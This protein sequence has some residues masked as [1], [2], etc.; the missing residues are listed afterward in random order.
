MDAQNQFFVKNKTK[1]MVEKLCMQIA[2]CSCC[3]SFA[4]NFNSFLLNDIS[5]SRGKKNRICL[6]IILH[7][8]PYPGQLSLTLTMKW[9]I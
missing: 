5:A 1:Q 4:F 3:C 6:G 8:V 2:A 7:C 9:Q